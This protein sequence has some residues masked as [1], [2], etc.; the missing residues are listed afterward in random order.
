MDYLYLKDGRLRVWETFRR[1]TPHELFEYWT[2]PAKLQLWWPE[3]AVTE[4]VPGGRYRYA[5]PA[6]GHTL[7]GT[8]SEVIPGQRLAFSWRW[9]HEPTTPERHVVVDFERRDEDTLLTITQGP[10]GGG[11]AEERER[12]GHLEGWQH[13]L[14]R[15]EAL[16]RGRNRAR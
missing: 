3:E 2:E 15:L 16:V 1:I 13:P 10:Y 7:T 4:P 11:K 8:F 6:L 12:Q 9:E 14:G 5:F